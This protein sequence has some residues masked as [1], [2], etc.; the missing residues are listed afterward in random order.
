MTVAVD[1]KQSFSFRFSPT[2]NIINDD[3]LKP[4]ASIVYIAQH[5]HPTVTNGE[6]H[7]QFSY[8]P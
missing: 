7:E 1:V 2:L 5:I 3:E 6:V 4:S 8:V